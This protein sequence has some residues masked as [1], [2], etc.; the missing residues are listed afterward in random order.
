MSSLGN[1]LTL[2]QQHFQRG[3]HPSQAYE[4]KYLSV[5]VRCVWCVYIGCVVCVH[6]CCVCGM[7]VVYVGGWGE[8]DERWLWW[9]RAVVTRQPEKKVT[10]FRHEVKI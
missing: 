8:V 7:G 2:F 10:K 6:M 4:G 3:L 1:K 9:Y 5:C